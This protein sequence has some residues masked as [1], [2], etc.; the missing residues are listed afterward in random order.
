[1]FRKNILGW[2]DCI[3]RV[4]RIAE[5][6]L[7]QT[8]HMKHVVTIPSDVFPGVPG[9]L[10]Q[11]CELLSSTDSVCPCVAGS[12]LFAPCSSKQL[13]FLKCFPVP[14]PQSASVQTPKRARQSERQEHW[15]CPLGS[16]SVISSHRSPF[17]LSVCLFQSWRTRNVSS[18]TESDSFD[19][20]SLG[21]ERG[22]WY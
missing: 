16:P 15:A 19:D 9:T 14:Y 1:M 13:M 11:C 18:H 22:T 17:H 4:W 8:S 20:R 2:R 21:T 3:V 6:S 7:Y 12:M 5:T 10:E